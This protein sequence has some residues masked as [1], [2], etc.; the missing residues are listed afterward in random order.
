VISPDELAEK[1]DLGQSQSIVCVRQ[2]GGQDVSSETK[3]KIL[4]VRSIKGRIDRWLADTGASIDAIDILMLSKAGRRK[5][6]K[7]LSNRTFETAAGEVNTDSS[8]ELF[9]DQIGQI[10]AV[11]LKHTPPVIS[12]GRRCMEQG[13]G[14]YWPPYTA[15]HIICPDGRTRIDCTVEAFVPYIMEDKGTVCPIAAEVNNPSSSSRAFDPE[16]NILLKD[17]VRDESLKLSAKKPIAKTKGAENHA[18]GCEVQ[19]EQKREPQQNEVK[20]AGTGGKL[21]KDD[22]PLMKLEAMSTYHMLTHTHTHT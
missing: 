15:P 3:D 11:L 1:S 14:F 9:S 2:T 10:D 12:I 16:D 20:Q 13:F 17:L 19:Q 7:L 5:V 6:R 18:P 4:T 22:I 8:I 21:N